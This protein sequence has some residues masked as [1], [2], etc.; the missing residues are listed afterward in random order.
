MVIAAEG[1]PV[2]APAGARVVRVRSAEDVDSSD[3]GAIDRYD[4]AALLAALASPG[5]RRKARRG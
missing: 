1:D 3:Q 4:R 5:G 2:A